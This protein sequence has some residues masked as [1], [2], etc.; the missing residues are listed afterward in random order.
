MIFK[1]NIFLNNESCKDFRRC[2]SRAVF[3]LFLL[4]AVVA[5]TSAQQRYVFEHQQMGT[6]FRIVLYASSDSLAQTATQ[7]AFAKIDALNA[8][9]SDY[10]NDSELSQLTQADSGSVRAVSDPLWEVLR[11]GQQMARHSQGAFDLTIGPLSRLWRRAFRRQT[12]PE[13]ERIEAARQRVGYQHLKLQ[14]EKQQV[15]LLRDS[16]RF[17]AGGIAK[18]Y[19]VDQAMAVLQNHE[20][21]CA[22]VDGGGDLLAADPPPGMDGWRIQIESLS[23]ADTLSDETVLLQNGALAT[24]GDTYRYLEWQGKR[25]AHIIDPRTGLGVSHGALV[26]VYCPDCSTADALASAVSVVGPEG[27]WQALQKHYPKCAIRLLVPEKETGYRQLGSLQLK[28]EEK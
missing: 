5:N 22:L 15:R 11:R 8:S 10:L 9:L 16:L 2:V 21:R 14:P 25:Y 28:K 4:P 12:F 20:I 19:A 17:D 24:S 27:E 18:G 7:A 3:F 26:S 1:K 23:K 6:L 13:W